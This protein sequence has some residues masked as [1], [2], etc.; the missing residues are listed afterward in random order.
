[1]ILAVAHSARFFNK[2][3]LEHSTNIRTEAEKISAWERYFS[4]YGKDRAMYIVDELEE[5]VLKGLPAKLRGHLWLLL[6]GAENDVSVTYIFSVV[7]NVGTFYSYRHL[8][9]SC[10]YSR[11]N[12]C[13]KLALTYYIPWGM[14]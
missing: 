4:V 14:E 10:E 12:Y 13:S 8:L 7:V 3:P 11:S 2:Y 5:L 9:M 6:S 1:M